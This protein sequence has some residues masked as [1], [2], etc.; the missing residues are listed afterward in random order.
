MQTTD[1]PCIAMDQQRVRS[2]ATLVVFAPFGADKRLSTYPGGSTHK[3]SD[4]PMVK[5]L[6][7]V[8]KAGVNV[9][10]LI[11]RTDDDSWLLTVPAHGRP[12]IDSYWK[13]DM[14]SP[15]TLSAL[16]THAMTCFKDTAIVLS[17]E[18]H[19]AGYL[20]EIDRS[21]LSAREMATQTGLRLRWEIR[22]DADGGSRPLLEPSGEPWLGSPMG[23]DLL[24]MGGDLLPGGAP[25]STWGLGWALKEAIAR[26]GDPKRKLAVVHFNNCFNMSLELLHTIAPYAEHAVGYNN[27]NFFTSGRGYPEVFQTFASQ[28]GASSAELALW[29]AMGNKKTLGDLP[30]GHPTVGGV[31]QL[32]RMEAISAAVDRLSGAL[33]DALPVHR[34]PIRA[35]I[36]MAQQ[37]DTGAGFALEVPDNLT[38]V[39]SLAE[40]LSAASFSSAVAGAAS[41]LAQAVA[42]INVYSVSGAPWVSKETPWNFK[43]TL[44]MNILLPDP[45]LTGLWDWRSPYYL[46]TDPAK[47]PSQPHVIDFLRNT[48]WVEFV[49]KYHLQ[50]DNKR[51]LFRG[52]LASRIPEFPVALFPK[53][54]RDPRDVPR[55]STPKSASAL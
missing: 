14:G 32:R 6:E 53:D 55:P 51:L 50:D 2:P 26:A 9:C 36:K 7:Q 33:I 44:A 5:S 1:L 13:Q 27:Y 10:A 22:S 8:A 29:L 20:P 24:P 39:A 41:D 34:E 25:I 30:D 23:G 31:V 28:G 46:V 37:Y 48:R 47:L 40:A 18:G 11:D 12:S 54:P 49:I 17:M 35:A 19:G 45:D 3:I 43:K 16:L 52:L 21:K 38:D 15:R 42:G 4:H